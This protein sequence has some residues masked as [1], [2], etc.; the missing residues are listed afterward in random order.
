[1]SIAERLGALYTR[2]S[3]ILSA[4]NAALTG[5]GAEAVTQL[6]GIA[7]AIAGISAGTD[8][9]DATAT[10]ADVRQG[11]TF[12]AGGEKKAGS[13]AEAE[14][15]GIFSPPTIENSGL[16]TYGARFTEGHTEGGEY[17]STYQLDTFTGV[18]ITPGTTQKG[19]ATAGKYAVGNVTVEGD[20]N[21]VP[22]NIKQGVSIFGVSGSLSGMDSGTFTGNGTA[23]MSVATSIAGPTRLVIVRESAPNSMYPGLMSLTY[24]DGTQRSVYVS[25]SGSDELTTR[26]GDL[27]TWGADGVALSATLAYGKFAYNATYHWAA[28]A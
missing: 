21:L 13:M 27:K 4:C 17:T 16:L 10:A 26:D 1:M 2:L 7:D 8:T 22:A 24:R 23:T 28:W 20:A 5:K 6:D 18:T 15:T 14:T 12:Y 19:A 25:G 9:S 11:K 3:G